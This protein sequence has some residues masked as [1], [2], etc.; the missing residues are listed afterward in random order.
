MSKGFNTISTGWFPIPKYK[1]PQ[2]PKFK[3]V[4]ITAKIVEK[5]VNPT[6]NSTLPLAN[7]VKKFEILP[8]GQDATISIPSATV[9]PGFIITISINVINGKRK[10]WDIIPA[11]V[12][13]GLLK[14]LEK[15]CALS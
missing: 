7:D 8:P 3:G 12:D 11:I 15:F 14:S 13:L 4:I 2:K 6:D 5:A 1:P 10:N 9:A